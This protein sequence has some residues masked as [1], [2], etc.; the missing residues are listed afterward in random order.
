[1]DLLLFIFATFL[2]SAFL[3]WMTIPHIVLVSKKKRLFDEISD[4]KSHTGSVPRLGGTAFFPAFLIS[5]YLMVGL[6]YF[7]GYEV[8]P[9]IEISVFTELAFFIA[10]A[11]VLF[12]VGLVDDLTGL[13]YKTKMVAQ[14]I[15]AV[16]LIYAGVGITD[17]GGI[18]GI[19]EV[20][21][22]IGVVVTILLAVLIINAYNLIDGVDGLC[23]SLS[24]VALF[25][26]GGWFIYEG[27]YFY[28]IMAMAMAG[29]VM[30][31]FFYNILGRRLKIFMG[32]TGSLALGYVIAFL[33][34]KF[35]NLNMSV[36]LHSIGSPAAIFLGIVFVPVFDAVRVFCVRMS[37]GLSPFHPDKRHIHHKLLRLKLTHLQCTFSIVLLQIFFI[38]LNFMLRHWNINL[39][40]LLNISLSIIINLILNA[41][42][43]KAA[44]KTVIL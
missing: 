19:H 25:T 30:T 35:Y 40:L 18:L 39:L 16:L 15:A 34:L 1:M 13:S 22:A 32:D 26:F 2:L 29:V 24:L 36:E 42:G 11:T 21:P 33:G 7:Y 41:A 3:G 10:G 38:L 14:I 43:K 44:G 6:R 20:H 28:A 4:R 17:F 12:F 8:N 5:L 31:F 9:Y 37:K 23:S 27:L